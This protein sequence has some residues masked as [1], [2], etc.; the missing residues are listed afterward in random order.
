[1]GLNGG[2][3]IAAPYAKVLGNHFNPEDFLSVSESAL[4]LSGVG[5]GLM[6]NSQL[7][8]SFKNCI[9][10]LEVTER[11]GSLTEHLTSPGENVKIQME[12]L[13]QK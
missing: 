6:A 5:V 10:E 1:M 2:L 12:P 11:C 4:S 7:A 9:P 8:G 3:R 13:L